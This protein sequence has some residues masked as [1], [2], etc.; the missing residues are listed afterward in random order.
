M[1]GWDLGNRVEIKNKTRK[2]W[3]GTQDVLLYLYENPGVRQDLLTQ[4]QNSRFESYQ[5]AH[6]DHPFF[7][8]PFFIHHHTSLADFEVEIVRRLANPTT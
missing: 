1:L 6:I 2:V 4:A 7:I 3:K 8:C 5:T